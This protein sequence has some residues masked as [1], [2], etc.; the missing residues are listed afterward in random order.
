MKPK[1]SHR[2]RLNRAYLTMPD[3]MSGDVNWLRE[4]AWRNQK[5]ALDSYNKAI[6]EKT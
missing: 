4:K 1:R 2:L 3:E 6:T 5:A